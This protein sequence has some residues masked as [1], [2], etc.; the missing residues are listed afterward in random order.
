MIARTMTENGA[1][2]AEGKNIV[3]VLQRLLLVSLLCF[4]G[5]IWSAGDR[6]FTRS[7]VVFNTICAKC[8]EAECS[9]RL[10]FNEDFKTSSSHIIRHYGEASGNGGLQKE[11]FTIL[12]YMKEKCAYYPMSFPIPVHRVWNRDLLDRMVTAQKKNYFIPV[13][14]LTPGSYSLEL[15]LEKEA[16]ITVHL[17]SDT[18]DLVVED[19]YESSDR[20]IVIPFTIEESEKYYVR[21]YPRKPVQLVQLTI[22]ENHAKESP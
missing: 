16:K 17:V 20:R 19:C 15:V 11:L 1:L 5:N 7:V 4:A 12:N 8:H 13:G 6:P 14:S 22:H 2:C 18:F 21:I 3:I 9:G 10:S